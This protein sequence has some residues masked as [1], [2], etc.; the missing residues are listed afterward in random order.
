V[1]EI[2]RFLKYWDKIQILP[3]SQIE[4]NTFERY[5]CLDISSLGML[6]EPVTLPENLQVINIDHHVTNSNWATIILN[7]PETISTAS[8]LYE[9]FKS[10]NIEITKET[11]ESLMTGLLTDSGFFAHQNDVQTFKLA[12]E[13]MKYNLDYQNIVFNLQ[14]QI[15]IEDLRFLSKALEHIKVDKEKRVVFIPVP[16]EIWTQYG[17]SETKNY[18]LTDYVRSIKGTDFGVVIIEDTLGSFR[19]EFR[20]RL[21][22]YD[23]ASLAKKFGGGGH[24]NASGARTENT[25]I[26][27]VMKEILDKA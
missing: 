26:E 13:L 3:P 16:N 23:V 15:Q 24:K 11:A 21:R 20:S 22:E 17:V 1:P 18:L 14:N 25:S 6:G 2:F 19:L 5:W 4:W 7:E 12:A 8:I 27:N 10:L 9:L